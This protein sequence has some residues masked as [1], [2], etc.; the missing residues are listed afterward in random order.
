[1]F[2]HRTMLGISHQKSE[3]VFLSFQSLVGLI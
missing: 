2:T 1:M 3:N